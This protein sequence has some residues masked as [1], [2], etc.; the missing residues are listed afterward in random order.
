VRETP[1][2]T[3]ARL[4]RAPLRDVLAKHTVLP[5]AAF[6]VVSEDDE[7]GAFWHKRTISSYGFGI[8]RAH[9]YCCLKCVTEDYVLGY[10]YWRVHHQL[11]G[12]YHCPIHGCRLHRTNGL[13]AFDL[14]PAAALM[15]AELT[16]MAVS[17]PES[18]CAAVARFNAF[19]AALAC[20]PRPLSHVT[21][22]R[23]VVQRAY[24]LGYPVNPASR[25][26]RGE[27][28]SSSH[29]SCRVAARRVAERTDEACRPQFRVS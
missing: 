20:R 11:P 5:L 3:F 18:S 26:P 13:T 1:I 22:Q 8:V 9:A 16:P 15:Q 4:H 25:S 24:D 14:Q 17:D 12:I 23:V 27:R 7:D 10:S 28:C 21:F 6:L 2:A 19:V 29:V